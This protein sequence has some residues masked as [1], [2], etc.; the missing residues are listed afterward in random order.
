[1]SGSLGSDSAPAAEMMM[2]AV[3]PP[4]DVR[5]RQCPAASSQVA[6]RSSVRNRKWSSVPDRSATS[7][8]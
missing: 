3:S 6:A 8:M 1:M 5:T 7:W 4:A 2:L